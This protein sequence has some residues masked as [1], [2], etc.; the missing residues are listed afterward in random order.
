LIALCEPQSGARQV[1]RFSTSSAVGCV[2]LFDGSGFEAP[3]VATRLAIG[4]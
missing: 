1:V 3:L 4:S 2:V